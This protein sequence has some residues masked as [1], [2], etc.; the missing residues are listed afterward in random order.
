MLIVEGICI[1]CEEHDECGGIEKR[2]L[3]KDLDDALI[4]MDS[5]GRANNTD[6]DEA[7]AQHVG[8]NRHCI[9][10]DIPVI[11]RDAKSDLITEQ[12]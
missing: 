4:R 5:S 8:W 11:L 1:E 3:Y 12:K 10:D 7:G 6:N 2:R 9:V